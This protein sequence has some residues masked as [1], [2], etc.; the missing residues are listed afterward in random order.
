MHNLQ[1][2][3]HGNLENSSYT[4]LCNVELSEQT[5][6]VTLN[7]SESTKQRLYTK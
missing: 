7:L 6:V 3:L 1:L 2:G 5:E 4:G